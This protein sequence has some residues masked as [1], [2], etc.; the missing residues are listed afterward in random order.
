MTTQH[1]SC[2]L[3]SANQASEIVL[4][5]PPL[6]KPNCLE[7]LNLN[8]NEAYKSFEAQ[9]N[10]VIVLNK[11]YSEKFILIY[12]MM[13]LA[14][15]LP[16]YT[17]DEMKVSSKKLFE[18]VRLITKP[19]VTLQ[20]EV[21]PELSKGNIRSANQYLTTVEN[22]ALLQ[23]FERLKTALNCQGIDHPSI[24]YPL[25]Q[26]ISHM[27]FLTPL[28][29]NDKISRSSLQTPS[30][31]NS[32]VPFANCNGISDQSG[33]GDMRIYSML[34]NSVLECEKMS[35]RISNNEIVTPLPLFGN[36]FSSTDVPIEFARELSDLIPI[37]D[38]CTPGTLFK[39]PN[40]EALFLVL[41][42]LVCKDHPESLTNDIRLLDLHP[43]QLFLSFT[44]G[45]KLDAKLANAVISRGS[46]ALT[47]DASWMNITKTLMQHALVAQRTI[48]VA[49]LS[50]ENDLD[51]LDLAFFHLFA[52]EHRLRAYSFFK[53]LKLDTEITTDRLFYMFFVIMASALE[54][55]NHLDPMHND[56][57]LNEIM[58]MDQPEVTKLPDNIV[59][60]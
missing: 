53:E 25:V 17:P 49:D 27:M 3:S 8:E 36:A 60:F 51:E 37:L 32:P 12:Q 33:N 5:G 35:E 29:L 41:L 46:R 2:T 44:D 43:V 16:D 26:I 45:Q 7:D 22:I 58:F 50:N 13:I 1:I 28:G 59:S 30:R 24:Q 56:L 40:T 9:A 31:S 47:F 15:M 52:P 20:F 10:K 48:F 57:S 18:I 42:F 11:S 55:L 34:A 14:K 6:S 21:Y 54:T 23:S 4:K 19:S 39:E 38:E